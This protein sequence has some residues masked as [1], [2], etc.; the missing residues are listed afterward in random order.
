MCHV[1]QHVH[2][3]VALGRGDS[4]WVAQWRLSLIGMLV[5]NGIATVHA[6]GICLKTANVVR[7]AVG[8]LE[9]DPGFPEYRT[10]GNV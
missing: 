6:N 2:V 7:W 9:K 1:H 3:G 8:N 5:F 10:P 4:R